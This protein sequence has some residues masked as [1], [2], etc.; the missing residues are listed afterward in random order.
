M[1]PHNLSTDKQKGA[2]AIEFSLIFILL[3][4]LLFGLISFFIPFLLKSHYEEVASNLL[5]EAIAQPG[6]ELRSLPAD[7]RA[8]Q[9]LVIQQAAREYV[10]QSSLPEDWKKPCSDYA[11]NYIKINGNIW[12]ACVANP[13]TDKIMPSIK[14]PL[15]NNEQG[16]RQSI[17]LP[18]LPKELRGEAIILR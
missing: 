7:K 2:V 15:P 11:G 3:F 16:E 6:S 8:E 17:S 12:S 1:P 10:E 4:I 13:N 18:N 5:K 14:L 9:E